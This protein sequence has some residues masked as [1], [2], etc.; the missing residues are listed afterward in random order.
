MMVESLKANHKLIFGDIK[1]NGKQTHVIV[2]I[3]KTWNFIE[4][5][6]KVT[7]LMI[8]EKLELG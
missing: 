2:D 8:E 6:V 5:E 4:F 3:E 1:L 7:G